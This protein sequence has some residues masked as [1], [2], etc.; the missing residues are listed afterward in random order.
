[1]IN[2][3]RKQKLVQ[4][5]LGIFFLIGIYF[6]LDYSILKIGLFVILL[7][8][9]IA[10]NSKLL[11]NIKRESGFYIIET[12]SIINK[13]EEM[14]ISESKLADISYDNNSILKS[15][16]LILRYNGANGIVVKKLYLNAEPWSELMTELIVIKKTIANNTYK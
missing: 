1:M 7:L 3:Y 11:T 9:G 14:K 12:Y 10:Y 2:L 15:H 13:K 4:L 6:S 16:N 5:S 8:I